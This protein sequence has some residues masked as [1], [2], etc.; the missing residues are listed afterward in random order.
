MS[1]NPKMT[2]QRWKQVDQLLDE[3]LALP[4]EKVGEYLQK[5]CAGDED[6]RHELEELINADAQAKNFI[7][8]RVLD[9]ETQSSAENLVTLINKSR[10]FTSPFSTQ[11]LLADRYHVISKLGKGGMGEVWHAYDVR[12]RMDVALKSLRLDL[13]NRKAMEILRRE[14]RTARDVVSSNICRIFDLVVL[15]HDLELIS[16]E[17][18]DGT[19]LAE[20]LSQSGPL[21]FR[22]ARDIAAQFLSGLEAIHQAGLV[23][24]DLKPENIMITRTG[25]VVVMDFGLSQKIAEMSGTTAGTLPY[26]SPEHL[27]GTQIDGRSDIFAAGVVLAEMIHTKG[28]LGQKTR[29]M[30][31]HAIRVDAKRIPESPWKSVI[32]RAVAVNREDRYP[33]VGALIRAL[34]EVTQQVDGIDEQRPYPGLA[35]FTTSDAAYFF[36]RELEAETAINKLNPIQNAC[37]YRSFW[38][39]Q[40]LF[41]ARRIDPSIAG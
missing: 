1:E 20:T 22:R 16:M 17:F 39:R 29:E 31:W 14:V 40:N 7:E 35:S 33:N 30:I 25:R 5:A 11:A 27:S 9:G 12:L 8:S 4:R 38:C 34:E 21:E 15:D 13:R 37:N 6:L 24:R 18:I 36:G 26:M 32:L 19:T 3:V 28:A 10:G 2:P 23:H 41:P